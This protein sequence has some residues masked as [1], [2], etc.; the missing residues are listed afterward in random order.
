MASLIEKYKQKGWKTEKEYYGKSK[1]KAE[2]Y[3]EKIQEI[4]SKVKEISKELNEEKGFPLT[5]DCRVDY[6]SEF[7]PRKESK[8]DQKTVDI[9]KEKFGKKKERGESYGEQLELLKTAIFNKFLGNDFYVFRSSEYDDF[10]NG[11]DNVLIHKK[12]GKTICAFD[13][14][15][16]EKFNLEKLKE[17]IKKVQKINTGKEKGE[18]K[19]GFKIK[20]NGKIEAAQLKQIPV[21]YLPFSKE[22]LKAGIKNFGY[23]KNDQK[24]FSIFIKRIKKQIESLNK[25]ENQEKDWQERLQM[26][27]KMIKKYE[28]ES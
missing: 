28:I 13:E 8:K 21:F 20:G 7:F 25:I 6:R 5:K 14:V 27:S 11:I 16:S 2:S 9:L 17:K 12:S 3:F 26:F 19:Y 24:T 10:S 18:L 22:N 23:K 15:A 4:K 1:E